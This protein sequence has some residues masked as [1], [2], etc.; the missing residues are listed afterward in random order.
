[1]IRDRAPR[2]RVG[3][4]LLA[5][6][7]LA[8]CEDA[9]GVPPSDDGCE[10]TREQFAEQVWSSVL[11]P[12]CLTC[13]QPGGLA[14]EQNARFRLVPATYPGFL[15][16]NLAAVRAIAGYEYEGTSL[17]LAKPS[18]AVTHGGGTVLP[19]GSEEYAA[20]AAFLAR[21]RAGE[22]DA[23]CPDD[24]QQFAELRLLTPVETLRKAS[25]H[26]AGRLPTT[27]EIEAVT[28]GGEPAL[29]DA[30]YAMTGEAAFE[31]RLTET[32][33]DVLLTD[34]Y[35]PRGRAINLL[36]EDDWPNAADAHYDA[37]DE[38]TQTRLGLALAREPLALI[39]HVV[40]EGRP[41]GEIL[42]ADYSLFNPYSASIY[43]VDVAFD[44]PADEREWREG[45][46]SVTRDG[47]EVPWAHAG[48]LSSPMILNR[49]PTTRT[50]LNRHRAWWLMR[51]FLATDILTVADRPVDPEASSA[52]DAPWRQDPQCVVCHAVMDPIAGA[53]SS[54]DSNDQ[55]RYF[56]D[57]APP[58]GVFDPGFEEETMPPSP[59]GGRLAWLA[60]R[61]VRD[62][63]FPLAI[64]RL[65]YTWLTGRQPI[66]HPRDPG[67]SD[68]AA[69]RRAWAAQDAVFTDIVERFVASELD[70]RR[71][72]VALVMT[73]YYRAAGV[74]GV[75]DGE[76]AIELAE[77][78]TARFSTPE[79]LAR[80]VR[81]I[82]GIPWRSG[83]DRNDYLV[84]DYRILY[85]GIDSDLVVER[86]TVPNGVMAN[87]AAR[88]ASEVACQATALDFTRAP[89]ERLLFPGVEI[90]TAPIDA[91]GA[92]DPAGAAAVRAAIVHLHAH[93][94][95][96]TLDAGDPEIEATYQLF[97]ETLREGRARVAASEESRSLVYSCRARVD[98]WTGTELPEAERIEQDPAYVIRSWQAV[99]VYLLSDFR[100]LY[101]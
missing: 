68:Y 23:S 8:G 45:R 15:D 59:E 19:E 32:W 35:A 76:R 43:E 89:G 29:E 84:S 40:R 90:D 30:V 82:A 75:V 73:P 74:D 42:T 20:F 51:T 3:T 9:A 80:R 37:L 85:G 66:D 64:T 93:V 67:A 63:R 70:Y 87:V 62:A 4:A 16:Q 36:N 5:L 53:F 18:G 88:M 38:A 61:V 10:T 47:V 1:M 48:I 22:G 13:H 21:M 72:V 27:A 60:S 17:L 86:L 55:E 98:R 25:L 96:E 99:M 56:P 24:S 92:P 58:A 81:A 26:L 54:F 28:T 101:E 50:N 52:F 78:G 41:F 39:A 2:G 91:E 79:L 77:V 94:L 71:L 14:W 49:F 44:D 7:L 31:E 97:L 34:R 100:F 12:T 46:M 57:R 6:A 65:T 69:R 11:E 33:N 95:G 83:V